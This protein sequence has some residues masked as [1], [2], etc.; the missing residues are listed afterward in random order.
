MLYPPFSPARGVGQRD[1]GPRMRGFVS[2]LVGGESGLGSHWAILRGDSV[3][4]NGGGGRPHYRAVSERENRARLAGVSLVVVGGKPA[5]ACRACLEG[6]CRIL[7]ALVERDSLC[8]NF[9][10]WTCSD[11]GVVGLLWSGRGSLVFESRL[12]E[13][14]GD[15]AAD[16]EIEDGSLGGL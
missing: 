1:K 9:L 4:S 13:G 14:E 5:F 16:D 12:A 6:R 8:L 15:R 7:N 10:A 11:C 3:R 2:D